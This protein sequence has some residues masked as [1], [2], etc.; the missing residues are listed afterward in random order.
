[1]KLLGGKNWYLARIECV[2]IQIIIYLKII[3]KKMI[4]MYPT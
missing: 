3:N 4:N 1:M 2:H